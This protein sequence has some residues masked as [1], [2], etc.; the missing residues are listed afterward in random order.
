MKGT[1]LPFIVKEA[2]EMMYEIRGMFKPSDRIKEE[3]CRIMTARFLD[4][5]F[6]EDDKIVF[7]T[8]EELQ[9]FFRFCQA[10]EDL[11]VLSDLGLIDSFTDGDSYFVTEKGKKYLD[12]KSKN[13]EL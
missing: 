8:N 3:L 7:D 1:Y 4:G 6:S 13:L 11:D 2:E 9:A 12:E 10:S 5:K